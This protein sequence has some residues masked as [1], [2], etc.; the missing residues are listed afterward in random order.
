MFVT[1][2]EFGRG[3]LDG[4]Y[5]SARAYDKT[6]CWMGPEARLRFRKAS[7]ATRLTMTVFVASNVP[8]YRRKPPFI[9][10][11]LDGIALLSKD[12]L[13]AGTSKLSMQLPSRYRGGV[14]P[15]VLDVKTSSFVP[16]REHMNA[17][18]RVLGLMLRRLETQ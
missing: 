11:A 16:A 8:L 17:D 12:A 3:E 7:A 13:P 4:L 10:V 2:E 1:A 14:G 5:A 15:Y 9:R 18:T 6:C